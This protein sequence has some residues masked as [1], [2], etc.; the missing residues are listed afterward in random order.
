[1]EI[2]IGIYWGLQ[3]LNQFIR[4]FGTALVEVGGPRKSLDSL[5]IRGACH[6]GESLCVASGAVGHPNGWIPHVA[7]PHCAARHS[8][9]SPHHARLPRL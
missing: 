5:G 7:S 3:V 9:R 1:M 8:A 6:P 4:Y 2:F